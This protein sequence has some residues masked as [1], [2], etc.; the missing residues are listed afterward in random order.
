[1]VKEIVV[2][3]IENNKKE[4]LLQKKTMDYKRYP[5]MWS[6]FGGAAKSEDLHKEIAR[7]IKEELGINLKPKFLFREIVN[8][9]EEKSIIYVFLGYHN[10]LSKLKIGEGAGIA[11][12]SKEELRNLKM[13]PEVKKILNIYLNKFN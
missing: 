3:I 2:C 6:F 13:L 10:D 4:F 1:M 11:F 12:H 8:L 7:E 5:G 9:G